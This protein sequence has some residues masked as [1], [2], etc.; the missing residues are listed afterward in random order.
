MQLPATHRIDEA[1][2]RLTSFCVSLAAAFPYVTLE[3]PNVFTNLVEIYDE[4]FQRAKGGPFLGTRPIISTNP[5]KYAN[6]HEWQSWT[7]VDARRRAI[8]CALHQLFQSGKVGGG[9][10]PTVGIWS[11]NCASA[12]RRVLLVI[13]DVMY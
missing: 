9:D 13:G 4:G 1:E 8:G 10:L 12:C 3:S 6:Y 11:K 2:T 7:E 5:L